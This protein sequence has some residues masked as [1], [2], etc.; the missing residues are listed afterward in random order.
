MDLVGTRVRHVRGN[1][2][3]QGWEGQIVQH[4]KGRVSVLY[5]NGVEQDYQESAVIRVD[6]M[7]Q[8]QEETT[9][10]LLP[11]SLNGTGERGEFIVAGAKGGQTQ[12][13][14][15]EEEAEAAAH[16]LAA[17]SKSG[18][19]YR[20]YVAGKE[21]KREVPPVTSRTLR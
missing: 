9:G 19:G 7:G 6:D 20:V 17:K 21:F 12:F 10:Y 1:S 18:Q 4:L 11:L 15:T 8:E 16:R 13:F 5:D 2:S 14:A 3:R